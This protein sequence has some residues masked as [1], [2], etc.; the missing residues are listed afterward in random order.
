MHQI[1][2]DMKR[3][4]IAE[5]RFIWLKSGPLRSNSHTTWLISCDCVFL[6]EILDNITTGLTGC[7]SIQFLESWPTETQRVSHYTICS[8]R[9]TPIASPSYDVVTISCSVRPCALILAVQPD[10]AKSQVMIWAI[11]GDIQ[12]NDQIASILRVE[13]YTPVSD[14]HI[15]LHGLRCRK[16]TLK[17]RTIN[18]SHT[19][20][21]AGSAIFLAS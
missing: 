12:Y 6:S 13:N 15:V 19:Y 14:F 21:W 17:N 7:D 5:D 8:L 10:C 9:R 11:Y 2:Y 16:I 1:G 20:S 18:H 4:I 3:C